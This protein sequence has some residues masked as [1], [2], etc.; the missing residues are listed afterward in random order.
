[1]IHSPNYKRSYTIGLRIEVYNT[2]PHLALNNIL[3]CSKIY[4]KLQLLDGWV[5]QVREKHMTLFKMPG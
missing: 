4:E 1:M 5:K 2:T 3:E